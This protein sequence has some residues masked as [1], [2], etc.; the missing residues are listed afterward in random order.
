MK[1]VSRFKRKPIAEWLQEVDYSDNPNYIPSN[2][3]LEF[4]TFIKLVNGGE[5]EENVSPVIHLKMLDKLDG[6]LRNVA[7][8]IFRGAGKTTLM[9]EYLI[10]FLAVYGRMP[11]F[12]KVKLVLYVSDSIDNGVK[13]MRKNLESRWES[14]EFLQKYLPKEG[15]KLTDIRWEFKN[16]NGTKFVV[17]GYGAKA[18][19]L[20]AKLYTEDGFTTI[21]DCSIGDW[22]YS[23]EGELRQI[24]KKSEIFNKPMYRINLRD[25]RSIDVSD[26]HIN[27]VV[28]NT[29]PNGYARYEEYDISTTDLLEQQLWHN[30][31]GYD[32]AFI[33]NT[34]A[35]KY[36]QKEL[37]IDPYTFGLILG[38]GSVRPN[39]SVTIHS[40][41]DDWKFYKNHIPYKQGKV[42]VDSRNSNVLSVGILNLYKETKTLGINCHGDNKFIPMVY[43]RG[44]IEQRLALLQGLMDTDGTVLP[45]GRC[46]YTS[47]SQQLIEDIAELVR[48]LGGTAHISHRLKYWKLEITLQ[49]MTCARLPRKA[50]RLQNKERYRGMI[51][52]ESITPIESVPS[53]CIAIDSESHQY[54]TDGYVRTHNTGIRGVKEMGTRPQMAILDDLVSND[55]SRSPTVIQAIKDTVGQAIKYALHPKKSK[56]IWLG[57]PFN[58]NDPLYEAMESG[59]WDVSVYP[60][61][62]KFPCT[63]EEFKGAWED[64]FDYDYVEAMY[65]EALAQG[66]VNGFYQELMLQIM[67]DEDRLV[68]DGDLR[69]FTLKNLMDNKNNFNFYITT[70]FA[71]SEKQSADFSFI[72]VWAVNNKGNY[73]WVDGICKRQTMDKNIDDLFLFA[74]KYKPMSVGIEVS[75]QQGGFIPWIEKEMMTRNIY[76]LLASSSNESKPGI[77]P[78]GTKLERF[79]IV[80]PDF[81]LGRFHF[82]VEKK[83]TIPVKEMLL[84]IS[85]ASI[86]GLKSKHDDAIDTISMLSLMQIWLPSEESNWMKSKSDIWG[87]EVAESRS[88]LNNY[89]V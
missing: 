59:A 73:F 21:G 37:P 61:C 58:A 28:L 55:D 54:L 67:S 33:K 22:V 34:E 2:F 16:I 20:T 8:M 4:L 42:Q 63:R 44:S 66:M 62:E 86:G 85:Q 81:K 45:N 18:L 43:Q 7:N 48:S 47:N 15:L 36:P 83:L 14:S 57:T 68:V 82:P 26:D 24:T 25:G 46:Q 69:W 87:M 65:Q 38:D 40:H 80:V 31:R 88:S 13:S 6:G 51:G 19:P 49:D 5:G 3:A 60:I 29:Q 23:P 64:R 9:A 72:S 52:I 70:D 84:E 1:E 74:N 75:G 17:K 41:K 27:S 71:T 76:F 78:H 53:Q 32:L 39:G 50:S 79:N 12:G 35:V 10:L 77:R 30:T 56:T 89:I 11:S